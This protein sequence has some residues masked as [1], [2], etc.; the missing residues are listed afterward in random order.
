MDMEGVCRWCRCAD[1][2]DSRTT[3]QPMQGQTSMQG[4]RLLEE[5]K[6][7]EERKKTNI[8]ETN[9]NTEQ[10]KS[11]KR[12]T[13]IRS[14][15]VVDV[16]S[17]VNA[18]TACCQCTS[19]RGMAIKCSVSVF[20]GFCCDLPLSVLRACRSVFVRHGFV[21]PLWPRFLF[22]F[23]FL[24]YFLCDLCFFWRRL[25]R[26]CSTFFFFCLKRGPS[27]STETCGVTKRR[28][29]EDRAREWLQIR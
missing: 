10:N 24:F 9:E 3:G 18:C 5:N 11:P 25:V 15:H 2:W 19:P 14:H 4:Y 8:K 23:F 13:C 29:Q 7:R 22:F 6:K 28:V 27:G 16:A 17:Y 1:K 20:L 21:C 12:A 26:P